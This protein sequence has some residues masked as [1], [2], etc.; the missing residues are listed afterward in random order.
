MADYKLRIG[1]GVIRFSDGLYIPPA[2][3]NRHWIEYQEWLAADPGN[4]PD[5]ADTEVTAPNIREFEDG[6]Y[7]VFGSSL[8]T[9]NELYKKYPLFIGRVRDGVYDVARDMLNLAV[10][11][12]DLTTEQRDDIIELGTACGIDLTVAGGY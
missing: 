1:G 12:T 10:T 9:S 2:T 5:A 3:D 8:A 4:I 11:N 6:L 7:V